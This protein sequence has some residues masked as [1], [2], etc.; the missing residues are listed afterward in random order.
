MVTSDI[1]AAHSL[2][3]FEL[4]DL[5]LSPRNYDVRSKKSMIFYNSEIKRITLVHFARIIIDLV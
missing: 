5:F 3:I 1:I 4:V 2:H